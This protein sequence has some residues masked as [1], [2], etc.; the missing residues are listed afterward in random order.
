[1]RW[2]GVGAGQASVSNILHAYFVKSMLKIVVI[3]IF[4]CYDT[5]TQIQ[6]MRAESW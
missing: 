6:K 4:V 2:E 3:F 5:N 1:M